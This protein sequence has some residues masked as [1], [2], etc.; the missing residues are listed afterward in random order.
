VVES[1]PISAFR[2]AVEA[3]RYFEAH[4]VLESFWV[5][6]RGD[7]RDF[8][9]GLIQAAVALH[10]AAHGNSAGAGSVARRALGHLGPFAPR[11]GGFDVAAMLDRLSR[12]AP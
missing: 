9:K 2:E 1:P 11:H 7:D 12:V 10:H 3:G 4:E 5:G 6:Y 8:Y